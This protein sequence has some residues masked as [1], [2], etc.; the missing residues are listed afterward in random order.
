MRGELAPLQLADTWHVCRALAPR[1]VFPTFYKSLKLAIGSAGLMCVAATIVIVSAQSIRGWLDNVFVT[2]PPASETGVQPASYTVVAQLESASPA[3]ASVRMDDTEAVTTARLRDQLRQEDVQSRALEDAMAK[4]A[5]ALK[6]TSAAQDVG[7]SLERSDY[8]KAAGQLRDLARD[9]DQL[10]ALARVQLAQALL[11]ASK[12]SAALDQT[13]AVA[14]QTAAR[15]LGRGDYDAGRQ[16]LESLAAGI[17]S[18]QKAIIPSPQIAASLQR[19][20]AQDIVPVSSGGSCGGG[21]EYY[22]GP[23]DCSAGTLYSTGAMRSATQSGDLPGPV[24][25]SGEV[26]RAGGYA[27]GGG[28]VSPL[29]DMVTRIEAPADNLV[30]VDLTPSSAQGRGGKPDAKADTTIISQI[31]QKNVILNGVPQASQSITD[32][33]E[34]TVVAPAQAQVVHDFFRVPPSER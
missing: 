15:A 13:L 14:E 3:E 17:G 4:L 9:S 18:R 22:P 20:Q 31:N 21:D 19:L 2:A 29:G 27:S 12:D 16:A 7:V 11:Q 8:E 1:Q 5:D 33:P 30:Q 34:S 32:S 10:S 24:A 25:G 26:G 28:N 23:V 6:G